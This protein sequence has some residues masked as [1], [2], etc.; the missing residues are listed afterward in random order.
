MTSPVGDVPVGADEP[1]CITG[2]NPVAGSYVVDR[3]ELQEFDVDGVVDDRDVFGTDGIGFQW[4]VWREADPTWRPVPSWT[5]ST[6]Q[7]DVSSF[8]VGEKVRVRAEA[9]DRTGA[10]VPPTTCPPDADDCVVASCASAPNACHKW[11]TWDL[12]LR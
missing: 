9:L 4:S 1:P 8:G 11:K 5:L 2:T 10:L 3:T 12:E 6:Y 7:L